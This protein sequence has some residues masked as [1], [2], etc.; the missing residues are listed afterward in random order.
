[1][2]DVNEYRM[3]SEAQARYWEDEARL[4]GKRGELLR[5]LLDG[6][7]YPN[8]ACAAVT[9][10]FH[11]VI[12][13][14]RREGWLIESRHKR[15]GTWEY[16]VVGKTEPPPP[17]QRMSNAQRRIARVYADAIGDHLGD[18]ALK[19]VL[20]GIPEWMQLKTTINGATLADT[21]SRNAVS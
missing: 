11:S 15:G 20:A 4:R 2:F 6:E 19:T 9:L 13:A 10:C 18:N 8:H 21:V 12:Y 5:L 7:W 16:R 1:M 3:L 14:L 17:T